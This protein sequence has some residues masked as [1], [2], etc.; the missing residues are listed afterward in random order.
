MA[1]YYDFYL[2]DL[3]EFKLANPRNEDDIYGTA[4][5]IGATEDLQNNYPS[6][7]VTRD[8]S[9]YIDSL[10]RHPSIDKELYFTFFANLFWRDF[11]DSDRAYFEYYLDELNI[12]NQQ[13]N[14]SIYTIAHQN[15]KKVIALGDHIDFVKLY[16]LYFQPSDN[17]IVE[18]YPF[19][20]FVLLTKNWLRMYEQAIAKNKDILF[21][22][23]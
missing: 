23:G 11:R 12:R 3:A 14:G 4:G 20:I 15:I 21:D 6:A 7:R 13:P 2:V 5:Y 17:T 22:I 9:E 10:I 1:I 16:K 8:T 18:S 19:E